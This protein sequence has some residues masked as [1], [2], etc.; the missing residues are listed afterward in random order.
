MKY[1]FEDI[2]GQVVIVTGSGRGIGR[3][4]ANLFAAHGA[5]VVV[6]DIDRDVCQE[7][8]EEVAKQGGEALPLVLDVTKKE[9]VDDFV[10]QIAAKWQRIDCLVNNAGITKDSSFL[11]MPLAD[12]EFILNVNLT[13][14]YLCASAVVPYMRKARKG[15]IINVSS[16]SRSGNPGQ[17][18]YAAAKAGIEGFTRSLAKELGPMGIRV[19]CVAPGFIKTRLTDAIPDKI[20]DAATAMIPLKR[21]GEPEEIAWPILFLASRMSSYAS[22]LMMDING[23]SGSL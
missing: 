12:W 7:A 16:F 4:T 20:V 14:A 9:Q 2:E 22:G 15:S 23:G 5:K 8:A 19:N 6:S 17:A 10:K 3:A 13:G 18:N 1:S 11:R 21:R